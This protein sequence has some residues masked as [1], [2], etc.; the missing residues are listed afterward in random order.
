LFDIAAR[1]TIYYR[2]GYEGRFIAKSGNSARSEKAN[3]YK[4]H[5]MLTAMT[6][7]G[8]ILAG[9]ADKSNIWEVN[10]EPK[11]LENKVTFVE[12]LTGAYKQDDFI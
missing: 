9:R 4:Y 12:N 1:P 7:V 2:H 11:Y 10:T 8:N 3:S 5:S 6:A